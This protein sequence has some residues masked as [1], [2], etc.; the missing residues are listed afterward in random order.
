MNNRWVD[1]RYVHDACGCGRNGCHDGW[2]VA[3]D[4]GDDLV[5]VDLQPRVEAND[6]VIRED[7]SG[8]LRKAHLS[9]F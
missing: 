2:R 9:H 3:A 7:T 5:S 6:D 4:D 8:T 1:Q